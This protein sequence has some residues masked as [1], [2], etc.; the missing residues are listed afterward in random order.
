MTDMKSD[1]DTPLPGRD[2]ANPT[3]ASVI[4]QFLEVFRVFS[5]G[6]APYNIP[7]ACLVKGPRGSE[8]L[9]DPTF[10]ARKNIYFYLESG[11]VPEDE[12]LRICD[13]TDLVQYVKQKEPWED[14]D[15]CTFDESMTWCL[16]VSHNDTITYLER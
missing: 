11:E 6:E 2:I 10:L 7:T 1:F 15:L 4:K 9:K 5:K 12:I 14:Y 3:K 13:A 16:A 8:V